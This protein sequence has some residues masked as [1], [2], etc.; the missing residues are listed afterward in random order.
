MTS[1]S[2]SK[3]R[4]LPI[5]LTIKVISNMIPVPNISIVAK[6]CPSSTK[7]VDN[8]FSSTINVASIMVLPNSSIDEKV[9]TS[10]TK[11]IGPL[12]SS[13]VTITSTILPKSLIVDKVCSQSTISVESL[14]C[15]IVKST[16]I[17]DS[18]LSIVKTVVTTSTQGV[19]YM[20]IRV[21]RLE[22]EHGS[23]NEIRL[24][25]LQVKISCSVSELI[26]IMLSQNDINVSRYRVMLVFM[27]NI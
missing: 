12:V 20:D 8:Q 18:N 9:F 1:T 27:A 14:P 19:G 25:E 21:S 3:S 17:I 23:S 4:D 2:D 16:T 10:S 13:K 15:S 26:S 24:Y 7:S 5:Y 6:V 22:I 11:F